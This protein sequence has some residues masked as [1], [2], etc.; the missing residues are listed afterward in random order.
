MPYGDEA[1]WFDVLPLWSSGSME[2]WQES[3]AQSPCF[4]K[5]ILGFSEKLWKCGGVAGST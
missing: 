1:R 2:G 3:L 5:N 4:L